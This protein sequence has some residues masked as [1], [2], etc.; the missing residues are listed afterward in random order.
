MSDDL[1]NQA[2]LDRA[3]AAIGAGALPSPHAHVTLDNPLCGDRVTIDVTL[4]DGL[5]A[6]VAHKVR[7]CALCQASAS[8]IGAHAVGQSA[9]EI[10]ATRAALKGMFGGAA[11][12]GGAWRELAVFEP[13][14]GHRSRQDCVLLPWEAFEQAVTEAKKGHG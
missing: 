14:R 3:K 1:Y 9:A 8:I 12:P 13:V 5:V 4:A 7:G 11:A 2:I 10:A 6:A